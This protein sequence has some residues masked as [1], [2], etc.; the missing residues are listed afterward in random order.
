MTPQEAACGPAPPEPATGRR[1]SRGSRETGTDGRPEGVLTTQPQ[2]Q[3]RR[4]RARSSAVHTR[5]GTSCGEP[6]QPEES[7]PDARQPGFWW[8]SAPVLQRPENLCISRMQNTQ[9]RQN[10][11]T[12]KGSRASRPKITFGCLLNSGGKPAPAWRQM[13]KSGGGG[14]ERTPQAR[15]RTPG[16][17][18][19]APEEQRR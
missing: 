9:E 15:R 8:Q 5:V 10:W 17:T 3:E 16:R 6:K 2:T 19:G 14:N 18:G 7:L 4:T 1:G 13:V 11:T 12:S